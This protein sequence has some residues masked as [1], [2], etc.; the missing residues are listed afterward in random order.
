MKV[1]SQ[2]KEYIKQFTNLMTFN[3]YDH[4]MEATMLNT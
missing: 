2:E 1:P 4:D 3:L